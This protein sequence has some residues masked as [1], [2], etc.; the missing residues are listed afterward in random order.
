MCSLFLSFNCLFKAKCNQWLN[1]PNTVWRTD[2]IYYQEY[3]H[4]GT[5]SKWR[6]EFRMKIIIFMMRAFVCFYLLCHFILCN[7]RHLYI[8]RLNVM[9]VSNAC[10]HK[11]LTSWQMFDRERIIT[12]EPHDCNHFFSRLTFAINDQQPTDDLQTENR[13]F[14]NDRQL[15][16]ARR[17]SSCL[18]RVRSI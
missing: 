16:Y 18:L 14:R 4:P 3:S 8:F 7:Y 2:N 17:N 9:R 5:K 11:M 15:N 13:I 6:F 1:F 10:N 12:K